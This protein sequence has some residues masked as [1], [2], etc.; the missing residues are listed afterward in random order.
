VKYAVIEKLRGEYPVKTLCGVLDVSRSVYYAFK[1][2][3]PA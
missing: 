3:K 1:Q 2:A